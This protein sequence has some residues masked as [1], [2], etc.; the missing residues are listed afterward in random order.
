MH[1]LNRFEV[2]TVLTTVVWLG[3]MPRI[4]AAAEG[5]EPLKFSSGKFVSFTDGN[6]TIKSITNSRETCN[7]VPTVLLRRIAV[8][9]RNARR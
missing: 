1:T 5:S 8:R 7:E 6:L 3:V 4:P 2:S 9:G